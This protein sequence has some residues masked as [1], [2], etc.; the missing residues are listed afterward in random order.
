MLTWA[1]VGDIVI[2]A[3]ATDSLAMI[4]NQTI[5]DAEDIA[6]KSPTGLVAA[7]TIQISF[8]FDVDYQLRTSP[9]VSLAQATANATWAAPPTA[10]PLGAAGIAVNFKAALLLAAAWRIHLAAGDA[11]DRTFIVHKRVYGAMS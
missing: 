3:A 11:A 10:V 7:A 8:D 4:S 2:T 9:S 6:I 5:S 1:R